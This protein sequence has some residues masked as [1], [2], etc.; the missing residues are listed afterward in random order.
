M[1]NQWLEKHKKVKDL[2]KTGFKAHQ[3]FASKIISDYAK[4]HRFQRENAKAGG[5][6]PSKDEKEQYANYKNIKNQSDI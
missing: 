1:K 4:R 5:K 3:G 6:K 2:Q